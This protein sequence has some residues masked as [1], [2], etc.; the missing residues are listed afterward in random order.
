[1]FV[2]FFMFVDY[3]IL[4]CDEIQAHTPPY[5]INPCFVRLVNRQ[6]HAFLKKYVIGSENFRSIKAISQFSKKSMREKDFL[7]AL[8]GRLLV[9]V[10]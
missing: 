7:R 4:F 9:L 10:S 2:N 8:W 6:G 5:S 3:F 1:M